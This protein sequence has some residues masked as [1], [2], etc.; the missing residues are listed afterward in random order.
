MSHHWSLGLVSA[1]LALLAATGIGLQGGMELPW[2][3]VDGGGGTAAY[4]SAMAL[5]GTVGQPDAGGPLE[6]GPYRLFGGLWSG[7]PQP[8]ARF[9]LY[10]PTVLR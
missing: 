8:A 10:L 6:G 3:S 2:W 9:D 5:T 7:F 4:G 1:L